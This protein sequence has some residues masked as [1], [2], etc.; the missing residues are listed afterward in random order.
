MLE[1]LQSYIG[2]GPI[3]I[4]HLPA[5]PKD[6]TEEQLVRDADVAIVVVGLTSEHEGE[7]QIAFGDRASL[8]LPAGQREW[9]RAIAP[10]AK[11]TIVVLQGSGPFTIGVLV[12]DVAAVLHAFYPGQEGGDALA[13]V[14]FGD[15]NPSGR[16][17]VSFPSSEAD[18]PSFDNVSVK[19]NYGY[20]HGYRHLVQAKKTPLFPFGH[21]LSY[22]RYEYTNL[23]IEKDNVAADGTLRATCDVRNTGLRAGRATVQL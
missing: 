2:N 11:K 1:G 3:G 23:R 4:T 8:D 21:G 7:A 9:I 20:L 6:A 13:R 17:P 14:L 10:L 22:T 18:L 12:P 5:P 15:V 16:L 19:V